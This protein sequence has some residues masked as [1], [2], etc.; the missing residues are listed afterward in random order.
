MYVYYN[1][2]KIISLINC[3]IEKIRNQEIK[4]KIINITEIYKNDFAKFAPKHIDYKHIE[5]LLSLSL[6]KT[7]IIK[8]LI[9]KY[10]NKNQTNYRYEIT[11]SSIYGG[12]HDI[13]Y[14]TEENHINNIDLHFSYFKILE[15]LT[16]EK[17]YKSVVNNDWYYTKKEPKDKLPLSIFKRT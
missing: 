9:V 13:I 10:M 15:E 12:Y 7:N 3:Y 6:W 17:Q 2:E 1:M 4:A 11:K 14:N 8:K 16:G 5:I